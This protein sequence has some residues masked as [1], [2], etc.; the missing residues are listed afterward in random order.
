VFDALSG[1]FVKVEYDQ[2]EE[3]FKEEGK[4]FL[5]GREREEKQKRE[6]LAAVKHNWDDRILRSDKLRELCEDILSKNS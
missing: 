3:G 1:Q 6:K 4:R 5:E 2:D